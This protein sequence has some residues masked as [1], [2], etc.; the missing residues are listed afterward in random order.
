M[1]R[2]TPISGAAGEAPRYAQRII[3]LADANGVLCDRATAAE[4]A[5]DQ[6][7]DLILVVDDSGMVVLTNASW[8]AAAGR[9]G[10]SSAVCG[11]GVNYLDV[12][13]RSGAS[14]VAAGIRAVLGGDR[15]RFEF[16]YPC[17][18]TMEDAWFALEVASLGES[19][20][21]AV[22]T[23]T[24][25]TARVAAERVHALGRE[26]DAVTML[27]TSPVGVPGLARMLSDAQSHQSSLAAVTITLSDLVEIELRHG[28]RTR[29][30]LVVHAVARVLR[31]TR[32]DDAMIRPST[33]QLMLFASVANAQGGEFL[34]AR[35]AEV[36][37]ETYVVG[38]SEIVCSGTVTVVT[39]DQFSTLDSLLY[40]GGEPAL[41]RND[42]HRTTS[43]DGEPD[44]E[45]SAN[46]A[47]YAPLV[48]YSLPDGCLQAANEA[49]R[50]FFGLAAVEPGRLHARDT[51]VP[52]DLRKIDTAL[53][54]LSSGTTDS[55]RAQRTVLTADGPLAVLTSVRRLLVASGPLAVVLTVPVDVGDADV[56]DDPFAAALVA[57][58]IDESGA[59]T[60][61]SQASSP[62]ETELSGALGVSL[63]KAVHPDDIGAVDKMLQSLC[64]NASAA[65]AVRLPHSELGWV[66]CQFQLFAITRR[67]VENSRDG[68]RVVEVDSL[69]FVLSA[70]VGTR[71]MVDKIARLER[72]IRRIGSEV[73][74]ADVELTVEDRSDRS[75][76]AL[77]DGLGMTSRQ[78]EI[79][80]RLLRGQR[81]ASIGAALYI[82]RST[83]RNHLAHVY[84]LA[85]VHSQE[86][87]LDALRAP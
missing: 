4:A 71:S 69:A 59:I 45:E 12:C 65:G 74:A 85:G 35:I 36:L 63:T 72:H 52:I 40:D 1:G 68:S 80:D 23:H 30:E 50:A 87:L 49:A 33:N 42:E 9:G 20:S 66:R 34:R 18:S 13:E 60:S 26:M 37:E 17:H 39:S 6:S 5:L 7:L 10:L 43:G 48:V 8:R 29:D 56:V 64:H 77:L 28:R 27:A 76:T 25:I 32:A 3:E 84:R 83:V 81:V 19:S 31:L 38:V 82:S 54:A 78:R 47:L 16:E 57:G 70:S 58:T 22:L 55:Y 51:S 15:V 53:A 24:N 62:M 61:V 44:R 11:C 73:T 86:A 46:D 67:P 14:V 79:V 75:V 41:V 21:G 2:R